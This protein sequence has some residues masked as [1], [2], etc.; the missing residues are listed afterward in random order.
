M[1]YDK[2]LV[3]T[4]LVLVALP[5]LLGFSTFIL[6][7]E[8]YKTE[9]ITFFYRNFN[10]IDAGP[11]F[12]ASFKLLQY[13]I[14][15]VMLVFYPVYPLIFSIENHLSKRNPRSAVAE[16]QALKKIVYA[17]LP[18]FLF[19]VALRI[20]SGIVQENNPLIELIQSLDQFQQS[21]FVSILGVAL[22]VVASAL[23]R[24]ILLNGSKHFKFYLARLSFRAISKV[25]GDVES[26][27]YL[28]DGLTFYNKYIRRTL[29]LQI[30]DLKM[31]YSKIIADATVDKD[32]SIK[33]LILAFED[34]DTLKPVR[35]LTGLF[36]VKDPE[37]FLIKES[38]GKKLEGWLS[39]LGALASSIAAVI[40][41]VLT[42]IRIPAPP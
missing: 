21:L 28:I 34:K 29:G 16:Y 42:V 6:I 26:M 9:I 40:G 23:L 31:I 7:D 41:A 12:L 11:Q 14:F 15:V 35:C 37:R 18:L 24:I 20:S 36:N 38:L 3:V 8:S 5:I 17:L 39:V 33:E 32:H 13:V 1:N 30:N 10:D 27:K 4:I 19:A 25:E 22:F 2:H